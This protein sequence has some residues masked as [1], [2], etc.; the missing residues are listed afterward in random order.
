MPDLEDGYTRIANELLE[1][2]IQYGFNK[3]DLTIML[4]IIRKTYGYNKKTDD[5]ATS[6]LAKATGIT[7]NHVRETL[8]TLSAANVIFKT[9]GLYG[10]EVG[11]NKTYSD[12]GKHPKRVTKAPK[13]GAPKTGAFTPKTGGGN[14]QNRFSGHPKRVA[15]KDN[16]QKTTK[17]KK[18]N[19]LTPTG[20]I[21]DWLPEKDWFDFVEH[22]KALK[23]AMTQVAA[24]KI[25]KKL[26]G[27][28][29]K[30]FSPVEVLELSIENGWKG[31]FEPKGQ[32]SAVAGGEGFADKQYVGS[33]LEEAALW[34][35]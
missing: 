17:Q 7:C 4:A 31:V 1:A 10:V 12:W 16:N 35:I 19:P 15:T 22:R 9:D 20:G 13:T 28:K 30:G 26:A 23:S 32:K 33:D 5:I 29:T 21:P 6:Q 2:I 14:T 3:R 25:V 24:D 34:E 8:K 18:N 11:I 27:F